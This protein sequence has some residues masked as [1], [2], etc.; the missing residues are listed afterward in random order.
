[1]CWS[2]QWPT[3]PLETWAGHEHTGVVSLERDGNG[4]AG[5][6]S[7]G[8]GTALLVIDVQRGLF[9]KST[10]VY[11]GDELLAADADQMVVAVQLNWDAKPRAA[12]T[13]LWRRWHPRAGLLP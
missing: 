13:A 4:A 12:A 11:R 6:A 2:S 7:P 10:P 1:M 3:A 9:S 5:Q 8:A